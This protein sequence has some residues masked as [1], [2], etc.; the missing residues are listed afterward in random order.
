MVQLQ[1][2]FTTGRC[3]SQALR[4]LLAAAAAVGVGVGVGVGVVVV[5]VVA[6]AAAVAGGHLPG[7]APCPAWP[8]TLTLLSLLPLL[9]QQQPCLSCSC[10]CT[11]GTPPLPCLLR[12]HR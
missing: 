6:V 2:P 5:A 9:Q 4:C 10:L 1:R 11:L 12:P 8:P 3:C 7:L